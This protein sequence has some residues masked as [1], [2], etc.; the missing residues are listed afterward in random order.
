MFSLYRRDLENA[1]K[2][3]ILNFSEDFLGMIINL[4]GHPHRYEIGGVSNV[5]PKGHYNFFHIPK[6]TSSWALERG[7]NS[8]ASVQCDFSFLP[9]FIPE[10]PLLERFL[11]AVS[12][13]K[14]AALTHTHLTLPFEI[15]DSVQAMMRE[16]TIKEKIR[17]DIFLRTKISNILVVGLENI[18]ERSK[19]LIPAGD[20]VQ[21]QKLYHYIVDNLQ[22]LKDTHSL[23]E[24]V[25]MSERQLTKKF[26]QA[27]GMS[28]NQALLHE[29]DKK[30]EELL[31]TTSISVHDVGVRVGY[32]NQSAFSK[33][34][35][36]RH[37][38]S[39]TDYRQRHFDNT[40][41]NSNI[42]LNLS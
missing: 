31:L 29:R 8:I 38:I 14:A 18:Q 39:P 36:K 27:F 17:R 1:Q 30:S 41:P 6:E 11:Q 33:A 32:K 21:L 25:K 34:F 15:L 4:S 3:N 20:L 10:V 22:Y 23:S 35:N 7:M 24:Q 9:Q 16:Q 42:R 13:H 37:G 5:L 2:L 40:E 12:Q 26:K 19:Q 28:I